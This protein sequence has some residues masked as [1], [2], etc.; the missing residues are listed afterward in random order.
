MNDLQALNGHGRRTKLTEN[1]RQRVLTALSVQGTF[2]VAALYA[3]VSERT[4]YL[5]LKKGREGKGDRYVRFF[6]EVQV[7]VG[8]AAV[9]DLAHIG[10]AAQ[11]DWRAAAW[12]LEARFRHSFGK[13]VVEHKASTDDGSN[14][15]IEE[16]AKLTDR[17]DLFMRRYRKALEDKY[18]DRLPAELEP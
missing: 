1:V 9:T 2:E 17:P 10:L 7:A 3:G 16:L 4:L 6:Q 15:T 12:R 18:G 14:L 13:Q 8:K 5:W 11:T